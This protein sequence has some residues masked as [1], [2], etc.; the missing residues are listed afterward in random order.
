MDLLAQR[1]IA[2][3]K[4]L[5]AEIVALRE[6]IDALRDQQE[7]QH[8]ERQAEHQSEAPLHVEA[9][10]EIEATVHE[11]EAAQKESRSR[12]NRNFLVQVILTIG[13][14]LAFIAAAIYAGIAACQLK[15]LNQQLATMNKTYQE[16]Q[17]QTTLMR[18]QLVS[19]VGAVITADRVPDVTLTD[20]RFTLYLF[21]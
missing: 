14:W 11:T 6:S 17:T 16:Y 5:R 2:A 20:N 10:G 19:T 7:R 21:N 15:T 9:G 4:H 12:N 1:F 8:Q 3:T 18:Q 13:T